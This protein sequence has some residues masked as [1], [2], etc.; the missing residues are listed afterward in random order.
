[1]LQSSRSHELTKLTKFWRLIPFQLHSNRQLKIKFKLIMKNKAHQ[2]PLPKNRLW[3]QPP[4]HCINSP[5]AQQT[6]PS[7]RFAFSRYLLEQKLEEGKVCGQW[8]FLPVPPP[9][10]RTRIKW[11]RK[12]CW[13]FRNKSPKSW[14]KWPLHGCSAKWLIPS[15]TPSQGLNRPRQLSHI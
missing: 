9:H 12:E 5:R 3:S 15:K 14:G 4:R 13:S 6:A 8:P 7:P 11:I 10:H 1:M 2:P